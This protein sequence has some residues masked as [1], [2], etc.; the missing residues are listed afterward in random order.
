MEML[1]YGDK[2]ANMK[3]KPNGLIVTDD[4][5]AFG[6]LKV[7]DRLDI[8]V[9]EDIALAS[10]NNSILSK[11]SNIPFTSVEVNAYEL[12]KRSID[13]LTDAIEDKLKKKKKIVAYKIMKRNSTS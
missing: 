5:V 2:I 12:G 1:K 3:D 10:F 9:P 4:L 8:R 13:L 11:H 7:F 6:V